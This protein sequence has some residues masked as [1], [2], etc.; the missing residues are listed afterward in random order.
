MIC[1]IQFE[2][3]L[4]R[5]IRSNFQIDSNQIMDVDVNIDKSV[6][7]LNNSPLRCLRCVYHFSVTIISIETINSN[8]QTTN[9]N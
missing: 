5:V 4:N 9:S 6:V 1:I 8:K 7:N 3:R 2:V